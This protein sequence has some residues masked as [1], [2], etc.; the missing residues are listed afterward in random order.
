[1]LCKYCARTQNDIRSLFDFSAWKKSD[2]MDCRIIVGNS[3][4]LSLLAMCGTT[5]SANW[6]DIHMA[7]CAA[8]NETRVQWFGLDMHAIAD[9][10]ASGLQSMV[11]TLHRR[12]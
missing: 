5:L 6:K 4:L 3:L 9:H 11:Q 10:C 7:L 8:L 2:D 12:C 1:M